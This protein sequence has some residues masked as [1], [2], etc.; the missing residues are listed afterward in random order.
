VGASQA[1]P[2]CQYPDLGIFL[3]GGSLTFPTDVVG[4]DPSECKYGRGAGFPEQL[5]CDG[6]VAFVNLSASWIRRGVWYIYRLIGHEPPHLFS[7]IL[8][9]A[10]DALAQFPSF[11]TT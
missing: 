8:K 9:G 1:D 6:L 10:H 5:A 11:A 2:S 7:A 4:W 3:V